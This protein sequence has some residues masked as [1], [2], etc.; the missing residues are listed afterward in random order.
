M[1]RLRERILAAVPEG[2][3]VPELARF[4]ALQRDYPARGGKGLRGRVVLLAAAAH[5]ADPEDALPVAAALELFQNWVL[6]HD[7]VEDDSETRRGEPALHRIAGMP[8]AVNVGDALHVAMWRTLIHTDAPWR[9]A[10]L[11]EFL[12]VIERT[13]EGQHLDLSFVA[14]G[15]FDVTEAAYLRMIERKTAR[16]TVVAPLRLGALVAGV[17]PDPRLDPAGL[18]LGRAFQIRDDVLNLLPDESGAYGKEFAGDLYE[19]KR[20]LVLARAFE[21]LDASDRARLRDLLGRPRAQKRPEEMREALDLLARADAI[22]Y[23]QGVAERDAAQ[24]LSGLRDAFSAAADPTA[25]FDLLNLLTGL[26]ERH[27]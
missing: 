20:T 18:A 21:V 23:A 16:Y 9:N 17:D 19:G 1:A 26:A 8:V 14:E 4:R 12:D 3:D 27:A 10:V 5:G 25:A 7:D 22:A 11:A 13:A 6:I 2:H 15:R 24:G